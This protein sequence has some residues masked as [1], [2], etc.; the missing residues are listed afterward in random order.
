MKGMYLGRSAA[1]ETR[2]R[3]D[4]SGVAVALPAVR[5]RPS[6]VER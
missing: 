3:L 4:P 2:Q 1:K 6:Q 5:R